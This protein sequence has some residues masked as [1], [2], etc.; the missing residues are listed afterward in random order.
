MDS[1]ATTKNALATDVVC[2]VNLLLS[3]VG[4]IGNMLCIYIFA[5]KRMKEY[6]FN[7]Y[8]LVLA[9]FESIFCLILFL[10]YLCRIIHPDKIFLH[11]LNHL[12]RVLVDCLY[13][14]TDIYIILLTLML[15]IDRLY[16]IKK[17]MKI[18]CFITH[19]HP[20]FLMA[21]S[22]ISLIS[23]KL[24]GIFFCN[25]E[26]E[27]LPAYCYTISSIIFNI[28]P[29]ISI[30]V[31]NSILIKELVHYYRN[32]INI[33]VI[34]KRTSNCSIEEFPF[35][36]RKKSS[37]AQILMHKNLVYVKKPIRGTQKSHY[38]V[39]I[40]IALWLVMTTLPYYISNYFYFYFRFNSFNSSLSLGDADSLAF[41]Q[42]ILT[43]LINSNHFFI[44]FVH[45]HFSKMFRDCINEIFS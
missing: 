33:S 6:V 8:L 18:K 21:T 20:K 1:N 38:F 15:S 34:S 42:V 17:P 44:F 2:T 35:K 19:L 3:C 5:Q 27:I 45:F 37:Q 32:K 11:Q 22:L 39:I 24:L 28:L 26:Y 25:Q 36:Y 9:I 16:A 41:Y 43:I 23:M 31:V 13:R 14:I 7:R 29:T 12:F 40:I 30:L 4:L 10:E